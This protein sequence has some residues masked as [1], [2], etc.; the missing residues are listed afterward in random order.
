MKVAVIGATGLVG[1][2]LVKQLLENQKV[3]EV[4]C[5]TRRPMN[6]SEK[7]LKTIFITSL[8]ELKS[9]PNNLDAEIFYCCLGT[10]KKKAKNIKA[11]EEVDYFGVL[12]FALLAKK[13][14]ARVF[15]LVSAMGASERSLF[16]YSRLKARVEQECINL[17]FPHL[18]IFRPSLLIGHRAEK[19]TL[20][21]LAVSVY[22]MTKDLIKESWARAL[23]TKVEVLCQ[24]MIGRSLGDSSKIEIIEAPEIS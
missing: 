19:R 22:G 20:E 15:V 11:F 10:T 17:D 1:I 21:A 3:S 23:G 13:S 18:L 5:F 12:D 16:H 2:E 24:H 9:Y 14:S 8:S 4:I 6:L 7:K